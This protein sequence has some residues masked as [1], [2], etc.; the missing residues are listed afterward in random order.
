MPKGATLRLIEGGNQV[1]T[2]DGA[3]EFP[4][5]KPGVYRVEAYLPGRTT[6][7]ILSNPISILTAEGE[8]ERETAGRPKAIA[9]V[10]GKTEIDRF[11]KAT[12]FAG[13][14]D[15]GSDVADPVLDPEGGRGR[16]AAAALAFRL[17]ATPKP[18]VWCAL[19]DRT[20]R[21]LSSSQGVSFWMRADGEYRM[22]FQIRD[23]NPASADEGTEAWFASVRTSTAWTLYNI[24]FSSLRSINRTTDGSFDPSK[25]AHLVFVIDHG[26]MPFGS[27]GKIWIDDLMSY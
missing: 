27:Q 14:H 6:P 5:A 15:P 26:A 18:P 8:L 21:D 13:E 17:N 11:E 7:W 4:V 23:L 10:E 20:R 19:V 3:L 24:P 12:A 9:Y 16:G 2:S 22:W 1:V 25:V